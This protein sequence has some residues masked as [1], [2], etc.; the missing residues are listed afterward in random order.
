MGLHHGK[1]RHLDKHR[2]GRC[3][4]IR[5]LSQ[6]SKHAF[7][8]NERIWGPGVAE[9]YDIVVWVQVLRSG[10]SAPAPTVGDNVDH[11]TFVDRIK[12]SKK[13]GPLTSLVS[14]DF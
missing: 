3:N 7:F 12:S 6:E 11:E 2:L 14:G 8:T 13:W 5:L 4:G 9:K 10:G 1:V